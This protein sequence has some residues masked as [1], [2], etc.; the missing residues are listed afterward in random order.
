MAAR[1]RLP[2]EED[3]TRAGMRKRATCHTLPHSVATDVLEAGLRHPDRAGAVRAPRRSI[4]RCYQHLEAATLRQVVDVGV[5]RWPGGP[6]WWN[7]QFRL[8]A[9][10]GH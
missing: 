2:I 1:M 7:R 9:R 3:G 4:C 6:I 5:D 8:R 10:A